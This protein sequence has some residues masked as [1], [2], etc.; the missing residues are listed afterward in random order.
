MNKRE[1]QIF[2]RKQSESVCAAKLKTFRGETLTDKEVAAAAKAKKLADDA[3][4]MLCIMDV[5]N[6]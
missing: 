6:S 1:L 4:M 2:A 5:L 3:G